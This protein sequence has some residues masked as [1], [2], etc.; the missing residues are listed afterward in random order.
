MS[1]FQI[2]TRDANDFQDR[3]ESLRLKALRGELDPDQLADAVWEGY[4]DGDYIDRSIGT[5]FMMR[6]PELFAGVVHEGARFYFLMAL[7]SAPHHSELLICHSEFLKTVPE[8]MRFRYIYDAYLR[9]GARNGSW[10]IAAEEAGMDRAE[11]AEAILK[12]L[13][14]APAEDQSTNTVT[15]FYEFLAYGDQATGMRSLPVMVKPEGS[16]DDPSCWMIPESSAWGVLSRE[17][18][19]VAAM[20]CAFKAPRRIF[21]FGRKLRMKLLRWQA[22]E[23]MRIAAYGLRTLPTLTSTNT[24]LLELPQPVREDL[25]RKHWPTDG[26]EYVRLLVQTV[27][28][29]SSPS[30]FYLEIQEKAEKVSALTTYI[31]AMPLIKKA[32]GTD[33]AN[34]ANWLGAVIMARVR[35]EGYMTG[36]LQLGTY[37]DNKLGGRQRTQLYVSGPEGVRYIMDRNANPTLGLRVGQEVIFPTRR[38]VKR[39][40]PKV[41]AVQ[42]YPA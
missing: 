18:L 30:E 2:V 36:V 15:P 34:A 33:R 4:D 38:A 6:N 3:I 1:K 12:R 42:F 20:E 27:L 21:E 14:N 31:H 37:N 22:D 8:S 29:A 17:Q 28:G 10:I 39:L 32:A 9:N 13:Y 41:F 40:T 35:A 16:V 5:T 24:A 7:L 11:I 23:I 19:Y 26:P 25:L